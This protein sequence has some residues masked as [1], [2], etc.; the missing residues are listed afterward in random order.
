MSEEIV[1]DVLHGL[2]TRLETALAVAG[3]V[4]EVHRGSPVVRA[5][6]Q[7]NSAAE[8]AFLA[9]LIVIL[10]GAAERTSAGRAEVYSVIDPSPDDAAQTRIIW[11]RARVEL[12]LELF[13][14][15]PS[16]TAREPIARVVESVLEPLELGEPRDLSLVLPSSYNA[17]ARCWVEGYETRDQ[18]LRA[19]EIACA[20]WR[21][22]AA[23]SLLEHADR[24]RITNSVE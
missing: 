1:T 14:Y 15:T 23:A 24:I 16:K 9:P 3:L 12:A 4:C 7:F 18:E 10:P 8:A 19:E 13:L 6:A 21:L 20:L 11:R 5:G 17:L 22:R 2:A